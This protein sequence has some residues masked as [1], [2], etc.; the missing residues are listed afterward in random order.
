MKIFPGAR[1]TSFRCAIPETHLC[2]CTSSWKAGSAEPGAVPM[3]HFAFGWAANG[4]YWRHLTSWWAQRDNP[5]VLMFSYEH[6]SDDPAGHIE[7]LA[8]FCGIALDRE[9]LEL[10]LERTSLAFMLAHKDKFD[11][12]MMR[13]KIRGTLQPSGPVA[14]PRRFAWAARVAARCCRHRLPRCST[15]HG[16]KTPYRRPASPAMPSLKRRCAN[17]SLDRSLFPGEGEDLVVARDVEAIAGR[18]DRLVVVQRR[19]YWCPVPGEHHLRH[20]AH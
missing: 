16:P 10:T 13:R 4:R 12:L 11:D 15:K 17:A 20:S 7:R 6:M 5:D 1:V 19:S 8:S 14:T 2:P 9:L 18:E 3:E